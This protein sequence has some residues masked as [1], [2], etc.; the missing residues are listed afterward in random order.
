MAKS[1]KDNN[2]TTEVTNAKKKVSMAKLFLQKNKINEFQQILSESASKHI[3]DW[4]STGSYSL[5]KVLSGSINKGFANNR[6]YCIAGP[7][8]TGKSLI[9]AKTVAEAQ[10]IGY[11]IIYFDTEGAIDND[12]MAR[13]GV[14]TEE[15]IRIPVVTISEFRNQAIDTIRKW[16]ADDNTKDEKLLIFCDS[17]GNLAG[18]K[19]M[20]DVEEGKSASDMGQRAKELRACARML[21]SIAAQNNVPIIVT[22]HSYEQSAANPQAAPIQKM[23]GGEGFMYAASA[24]IFL[25]KRQHK[26]K[27]ENVLGDNV[28]KKLGNFIIATAEKNRFV[29]EGTK[30]EIYASFDKGISP[31][32]GLLEDAVEAG[33]IEIRSTRYYVKHLDKSVWEKELYKHEI[34]KP[35]LND[36]NAFIENKYKFSSITDEEVSLDEE[37]VKEKEDSEKE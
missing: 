26:E 8:S 29:P 31:Y 14:N 13:F 24:V 16:R 37:D 11:T 4:I 33:L 17:I 30:G 10:K 32:Y 20:N 36:L 35:I 34:W 3:S 22:N 12:F 23:S 28:N 5:N 1:K 15:L 21:T 7:S 6:V 2:E 25:K 9:C 19:E 27:S 18:T